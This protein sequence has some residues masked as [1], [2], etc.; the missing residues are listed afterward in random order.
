[1]YDEQY[2]DYKE[3]Y[4]NNE[5]ESFDNETDSYY[6]DLESI[7]EVS[8]NTLSNNKKYKKIVNNNF[9]KFTKIVNGKIVKIG[10]Y[11]TNIT[12]GSYIRN[13]ITG[14]IYGNIH[15]K[16]LV[17]SYV[18]DLFFKVCNTT[19]ETGKRSPIFMF[20][21]SPNEFEKHFKCKISDEVKEKW[22]IKNINAINKREK[23]LQKELFQK[24][25]I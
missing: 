18:E 5:T 4:L 7:S 10:F 22:K 16:I 25:I 8:V 2:Y 3:Q 12:P 1:M 19:I 24:E 15:D 17:G 13:A 6:T 20:F 14:N 23:L 9:N 11:E 21:N